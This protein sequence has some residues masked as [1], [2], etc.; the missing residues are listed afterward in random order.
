M[1]TL[2]V[3]A[4][5]KP[6]KLD[7]DDVASDKSISHRSALFSLLSDKPSRIYNFLQ[8]EDTLNMLSIVSQ[9][10]A[11][12]KRKNDYIVIS[13]P[14]NLHEPKDVLDCGNAGTAIRLLM[15]F[16]STKK[17]F[18]ILH[19]DTYLS[20]RPMA[21]IANPLRNIGA[22]ID[23]R[24]NGN[25]SPICI[26]GKELKPFNYE[27]KI[28]SAQV[29]SALILCALNLKKPS[30]FTEN[31][32]SRDHSERMLKGMGAK[33]K[34]DKNSIIIYPQLKP[35]K[36][37]DI[38]V[39]T[40]PSSGFFFAVLVA[41]IPNSQITLKNILLNKTRIE[42][43]KILKKM[44]LHVSFKLKSNKYDKIGDITIKHAPLKAI[45]VEKNISWLI[46]EIP[47]LAIAFAHAKGIS[48]VKNAK[49]LRV[50]ESDRIST[51]VKN[52]RKCGIEVTEK[53][54]GFLVK[55]GEMKKAYVKSYGDHR[56]A[57]S[58]IIAG[59]KCGMDVEDIK[60]VKTSFPNFF[61]LIDR[62][63]K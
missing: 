13:P 37:L 21:R 5:T 26:R 4:L 19:G 24:D 56:I 59:L 60:C 47:A 15:G 28:S 22:C 55:G 62:F 31:Q 10:G 33:I 2:H 53:E 63:K 48:E 57:M 49:E 8:G 46:D 27:S 61:D 50:K 41:L 45:K 29:K 52:L 25:L 34:K 36:P 58:F 6:F 20:S 39:P 12:V 14:K 44:G 54:D 7:M 30:I 42:A 11:K 23:G 18:F 17:G 32:L 9:L 43:Y 1:K 35:L 16:L 40:D 3:K 51:V 38:T